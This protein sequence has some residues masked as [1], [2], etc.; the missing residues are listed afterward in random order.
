MWDMNE[1]LK[2][3]NKR[4]EEVLVKEEPQELSDAMRHI[5]L[6]GGKRLRP[7][8][9][10]HSAGAIDTKTAEKGMEAGVALELIHNFTLIHDDIMDKSQMRRHVKTTHVVFGEDMSIN[11][12]DAMFAKAF[13]MFY[14]L[15][16]TRRLVG[17]VSLMVHDLCKGQAMDILG[18]RNRE[19]KDLKWYLKMIE[20]KTARLLQSSARCGAIVAGAT[21]NETELL[22]N[23]AW[24][25]GMAFQIQDDL[26]DAV[27]DDAKTGKAVGGDIKEGKNTILAVHALENASEKDRKII[28]EGLG[29]DDKIKEVIEAFRRAGSMDFAQK[30]ASEYTENARKSLQKLKD[31]KDKEILMQILD[32][33]LKREK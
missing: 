12:G 9:T 4:I 1:D 10:M 18:G 28:R 14:E 17:E 25:L 15:P 26:L 20:Y 23:F 5:I 33:T 24:N 31:S 22:G 29:R 3:I 27:G 13:G 8:I 21:E 11:A 19:S 6:S 32:Y 2:M 7:I 16:H 30:M